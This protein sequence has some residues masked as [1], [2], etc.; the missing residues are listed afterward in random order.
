M[1][2][3]LGVPSVLSA[4]RIGAKFSDRVYAALRSRLEELEREV[5]VD[6][7]LLAERQ[8][9]LDACPCPIHGP[10][11]P[12]VVKRLE[13]LQ[14]AEAEL[15]AI[16]QVLARRPALDKPTRVENINHAIATVIRFRALLVAV[17]NWHGL[18]GDGISDPLRQQ[19][20]DAL[21]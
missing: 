5:A 19:I 15:R 2:A 14:A 18:D 12:H 3:R 16:D 17:S 20:L 4:A 7:A 8:R 13:D 9:I 10:C 11:V 6:D 1:V 21:K